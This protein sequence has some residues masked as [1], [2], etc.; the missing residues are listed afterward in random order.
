M[1]KFG[2]FFGRKD[3][4]KEGANV[5]KDTTEGKETEVALKVIEEIDKVM[6]KS[7]GSVTPIFMGGHERINA[8]CDKSNAI[9]EEIK[10]E[11]NKNQIDAVHLTWIIS[12]SGLHLRYI[13]GTIL[14]EIQRQDG[15]KKGFEIILT[16]LEFAHQ[17][18]TEPEQY[19]KELLSSSNKKIMHP[20]FSAIVTSNNRVN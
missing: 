1:K 9:K 4:P 10:E 7:A 5:C 15:H 20:V 16:F 3:A 12:I 11:F 18:I 2:G 19:G 14:I 8:L 17:L 13:D 6:M